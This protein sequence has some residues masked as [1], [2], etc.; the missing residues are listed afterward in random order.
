MS[1]VNVKELDTQFSL[2]P[3]DDQVTRDRDFADQCDIMGYEPTPQEMEMGFV[4]NALCYIRDEKPVNWFRDCI[5]ADGLEITSEERNAVN[6]HLNSWGENNEIIGNPVKELATNLYASL[7]SR[8]ADIVDPKNSQDV[9][10][11]AKETRNALLRRNSDVPLETT[12]P[13]Q[14]TSLNNVGRFKR[15]FLKLVTP[16]QHHK[17]TDILTQFGFGFG[18]IARKALEKRYGDCLIALIQSGNDESVKR[19]TIEAIIKLNR[20]YSL[21]RYTD[22]QQI[23]NSLNLVVSVIEPIKNPILLVLNRKLEPILK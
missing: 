23:T 5:S 11:D 6:Q 13:Y 21:P 14:A 10:S 19:T 18:I 22:A 7:Q 2:V 15:A 4:R 17:V 8:L 9:I 16:S 1:E 12:V 3:R 20:F